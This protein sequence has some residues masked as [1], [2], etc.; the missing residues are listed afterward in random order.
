MPTPKQITLCKLLKDVCDET[1]KD[2]YDQ[3]QLGLQ[4][5]R[6]ELCQKA[7]ESKSFVTDFDIVIAAIGEPLI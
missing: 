2:S 7:H 4:Q 3:K 6:E 5:N 1:L